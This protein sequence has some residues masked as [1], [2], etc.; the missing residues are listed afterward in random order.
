MKNVVETDGMQ[1]GTFKIFSGALPPN[2]QDLSLKTK[3]VRQALQLEP[4]GSENRNVH[5]LRSPGARVASQYRPILPVTGDILHGYG[6]NSEE[7]FFSNI[8]ND[9]IGEV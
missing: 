8:F 1:R 2:P 6:W 5:R 7:G 3:P 4:E 9:A